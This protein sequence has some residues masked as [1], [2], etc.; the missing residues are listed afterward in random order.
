MPARVVRDRFIESSAGSTVSE[1]TTAVSTTRIVPSAKPM[2]IPLPVR[3]IPAMATMTVMPEMS[4]ARP[5]VA[6]GTSTTSPATD[7]P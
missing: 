2:K 6:A 3:N 5:D 1:P 4:T 7:S